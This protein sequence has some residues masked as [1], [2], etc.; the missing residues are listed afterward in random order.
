MKFIRSGLVVV[1]S[2]TVALVA[3]GQQA[4]YERSK[5]GFVLSLPRFVSAMEQDTV[6]R[7]VGLD[8]ELAQRIACTQDSVVAALV[9]KNSSATSILASLR[10]LPEVRDCRLKLA[11]SV[12]PEVFIL[13]GQENASGYT[14]I[15]SR[16]FLTNVS[17][18]IATGCNSANYKVC[19]AMHAAT[20][21][22][23]QNR[24]RQVAL[25]N[26]DKV[27]EY[28]KTWDVSHVSLVRTNDRLVDEDLGLRGVRRLIRVKGD[29]T[30]VHVVYDDGGSIDLKMT[31]GNPGRQAQRVVYFVKIEEPAGPT[32]RQQVMYPPPPPAEK[33][34]CNCPPQKVIKIKQPIACFSSFWSFSFTKLNKVGGLQCLIIAALTW[35][36]IELS[37]GHKVSAEPPK[38]GGPPRGPGG[39]PRGP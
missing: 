13:E 27:L 31:C 22:V 3:S 39:A 18:V 11:G 19:F 10:K 30:T 29:V 1:L 34:P 25:G 37:K 14:E 17:P 33:E 12:R 7:F 16:V 5:D 6:M 35:G 2:A 8:N 32:L 4:R 36:G 23:F 26:T 20:D 9:S 28:L 38:T 21:T 15:S 24:I